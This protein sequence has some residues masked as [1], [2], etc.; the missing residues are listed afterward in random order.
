MTALSKTQKAEADETRNKDAEKARRAAA[1]K[2]RTVEDVSDRFFK[3]RIAGG[4]RR[5]TRRKARLTK[6]RRK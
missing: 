6:S 4:R 5:L 3:M 1:T 2:K